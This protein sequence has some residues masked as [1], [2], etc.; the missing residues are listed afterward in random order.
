M[1]KATRQ[2]MEPQVM[3]EAQQTGLVEEKRTKAPN[4]QEQTDRHQGSDSGSDMKAF[5]SLCSLAG[6]SN[7]INQVRTFKTKKLMK[8]DL[9]LKKQ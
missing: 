8:T 2:H 5:S 6:R 9:R 3:Q 7:A 1:Q 4:Q